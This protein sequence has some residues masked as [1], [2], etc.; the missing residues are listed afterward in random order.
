MHKLY[1][2][3]AITFSLLI[4][5][6]EENSAKNA[7]NPSAS[8]EEVNRWKNALGLWEGQTP[9]ENGDE[10]HWL[11]SLSEEGHFQLN[12]TI[13]HTDG[14][15]TKQIEVG[16]WGIDG[17]I[18]FVSPK[19]VIEEGNFVPFDTPKPDLYQAYEILESSSERFTIKHIT[20]GDIFKTR[21]ISTEVDSK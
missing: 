2:A 16:D 6:T 7:I 21:R 5:C 3:L 1:L 20:S 11:L 14:T 18:Y 12:A 19:G 13:S 9:I 10:Y 15:I 17:N 8:E 4:G